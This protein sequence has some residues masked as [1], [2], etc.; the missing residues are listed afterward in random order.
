MCNS[1]WSRIILLHMLQILPFCDLLLSSTD[2]AG[3]LKKGDCPGGD[4]KNIWGFVFSRK[5]YGCGEPL[6]R[7]GLGDRVLRGTEDS[8]LSWAQKTPQLMERPYMN[9][10]LVTHRAECLGL[11]D[12]GCPWR[13]WHSGAE[14]VF[15]FLWGWERMVSCSH[16]ESLENPKLGGL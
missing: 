5:G 14:L 6:H 11:L 13:K 10:L 2:S 9:V 4:V 15:S 12:I 1:S 3:W 16:L 7:T 8:M